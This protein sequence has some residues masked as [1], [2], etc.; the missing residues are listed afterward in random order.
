MK[1]KF[2]NLSVLMVVA[3]L[4]AS[5]ASAEV[6]R[7]DLSLLSGVTSTSASSDD[8]FLALGGATNFNGSDAGF[9][10]SMGA[11]VGMDFISMLGFETGLMFMNHKITG[12]YGDPQG[13]AFDSTDLN[14]S[15]NNLA[16]PL[17]LRFSPLEYLSLEA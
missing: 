6:G 10:Y 17:L 8:F 4:V 1:T 13:G 11:L 7:V 16:V 14:L 2:M 3:T 12:S 9:S 5:T 15:Y